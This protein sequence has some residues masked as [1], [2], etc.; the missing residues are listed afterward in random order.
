MLTD[1][2]SRYNVEFVDIFIRKVKVQR[3]DVKR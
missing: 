3:C 2:L 1:I